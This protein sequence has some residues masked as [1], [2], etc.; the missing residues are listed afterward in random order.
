MPDRLVLCHEAGR[1][2]VHGYESF[3]LPPLPE[4]VSLYENLAG[5][6]HDAGV[7][8]GA[9]NTSHL[10]ENAAERAVA[11]YADGIDAPATDP[12]RY[13]AGELLEAVL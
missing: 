4:Y 13:G 5:P 3:D 2:A 11:D 10:G 7:V 1:E 12:V 8:A 6:V 9:L